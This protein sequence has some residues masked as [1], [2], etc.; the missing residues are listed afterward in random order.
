MTFLSLGGHLLVRFLFHEMTSLHPPSFQRNDF[1]TCSNIGTAL[2][3]ASSINWDDGEDVHMTR[4]EVV[5]TESA[6][7]VSHRY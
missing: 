1:S 4:T 5:R 2:S 6:L 7:S 3:L